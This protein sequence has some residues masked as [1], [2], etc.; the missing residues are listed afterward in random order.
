M[1]RIVL[2]PIYGAESIPPGLETPP[3][4]TALPE[5]YYHRLTPNDR[6]LVLATDGLWEWLEPETV[7]RLISDHMLGVQTLT[8]YQ[9]NDETHLTQ[10]SC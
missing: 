7:V 1:L 2:E 10:V 6:F 5:V 4:L 9:P 3:Y 8:P